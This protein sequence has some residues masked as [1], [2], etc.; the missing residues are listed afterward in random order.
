M[1]TLGDP[2]L[3]ARA[4]GNSA[5]ALQA[6]GSALVWAIGPAFLLVAAW[7]LSSSGGADIPN[8]PAAVVA[9][10]DVKAGGMRRPLADASLSNVGGTVHQCNE[11]HKLFTSQPGDKRKLMQHQEI[12]LK[13]GMNTRCFNCHDG[14]NRDKLVLHDGTLIDFGET[15]RLCSQCHGTVYRDWQRGMH[16]KTMGSWDVT[17]GLQHR[18]ACN[19]CHNPHSPAYVPQH[20]LPGPRTLRMGDQ[21]QN[22][23]PQERH[24][25]LRRWSQPEIPEHKPGPKVAPS[26]PEEPRS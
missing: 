22:E 16:G 23:E 11:C 1:S 24:T 21:S 12:D 13:H 14:A 6:K 17:S 19:E 8:T 25:P 7:L 20:P 18:L 26:A 3:Q 2:E 10:D 15:P 4:E 9:A 5:A